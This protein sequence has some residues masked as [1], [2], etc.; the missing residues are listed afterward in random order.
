MHIGILQTGHAP[1][2][3]QAETG[4]YD[5][6]F[7][8]FLGDEGFS[9]STF[10]VVDME[11]PKTVKDCDAWLV[12]GSRHG[13]YEDHAF[14]PPLEEFIRDAFGAAIPMV[15]V[16]FGHQII[17]QALGGRVEKFEGGWAVGRQTY[18]WDGNEMS[19]NA[20]HQDQVLD[21]PEGATCLAGNEFCKNAA[22]LYG[23]RAFTVQPHPEF[24]A[25][26]I[27]G[28]IEYRGPGTVPAPLLDT[29]TEALNTPVANK[30]L[31]EMVANFF[32]DGVPT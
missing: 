4:D 6:M 29:A 32:R 14:I 2:E 10:D 30:R 13:A 12:T 19:L 26:V 5:A 17:A 1:E 25:N 3:I 11:F 20:W 21:V 24:G 16:C 22:L 9:F 8:R 23:N 31:A 7:K 27:K 18:D 15:G 28:L